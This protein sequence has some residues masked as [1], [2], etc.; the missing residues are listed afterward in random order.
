M[1]PQDN[2]C[3]VFIVTDEGERVLTED[4]VRSVKSTAR[5][6]NIQPEEFPAGLP[7][8]NS[9]SPKPSCLIVSRRVFELCGTDD[10]SRLNFL[11]PH[12]PV[13]VLGDFPGSTTTIPVV[14]V[15][16]CPQK[17]SLAVL[18]ATAWSERYLRLKEQ[19]ARIG[20][21]SE[22]ELAIVNM[23]SDGLPN[24]AVA[25]KLGVSIKTVEKNRRAAYDKLK[26]SST[27]SMATLVAFH[28]YCR[29]HSVMAQLD[30]TPRLPD[31][32]IAA[33][34]TRSDFNPARW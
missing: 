9:A 19:S 28:R 4:S 12:V 18:E 3:L 17:L 32:G 1:Q 27:A 30:F 25:A 13:I 5:I 6:V 24:K 14:S 21:L 7:T 33:T 20:L 26:V 29:Q 31:D 23:A 16:R 10:I 15:T 11:L 2:E 22:R 34:A 8:R